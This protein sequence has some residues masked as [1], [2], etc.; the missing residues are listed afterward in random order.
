MSKELI[1]IEKKGKIETVNA[2]E[3][4]EFLESKQDFSTWIKS[5]ISKYSFIENDDYIRLHK[6]MEAN[7]ATII[8]YHISVDMAKEL[9][10]VENNDK[11]KQAR[12][13]FIECENKVRNTPMIPSDFATA[14]RLAADQAE[15][16]A[17]LE[18]KADLADKAI[19]D[20]TTQYSIRDAGKHIGLK[21]KE[22]FSIMRDKKLLTT[23]SMPTQKALDMTVLSI[24][25]NIIDGKNYR[26]AVMTMQNIH[27]FNQRYN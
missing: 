26:Q 21:Q 5:R 25:T 12:R 1:K 3:L 17:L 27:E 14:L 10:M 23:K 24:R 4:H 22:I 11:G 2:R 20:E 7:N 9:S 18:P 15:K 8:E 16:I 6:K 19:R 13:Y